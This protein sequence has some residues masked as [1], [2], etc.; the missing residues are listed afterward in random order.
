M[1]VMIFARAFTNVGAMMMIALGS[2][3]GERGLAIGVATTFRHGGLTLGPT[4][5]GLVASTFGLLTGFLSMALVI[6]PGSLLMMRLRP[7]GR[8]PPEA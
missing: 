3:Q 7:T 8:R 2:S 6:F 5:L 1:M 4:I